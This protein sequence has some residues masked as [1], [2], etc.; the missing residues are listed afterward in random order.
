[1]HF[2]LFSEMQSIVCEAADDYQIRN[3]Q[4]V[5]LAMIK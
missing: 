2:L 4:V 1:M 5:V 3:L